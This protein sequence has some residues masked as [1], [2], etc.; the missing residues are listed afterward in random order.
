MR[1]TLNT[2]YKSIRSLPDTEIPDLVV[3]TGV[4]GAGKSHLLQAIESGAVHIEGIPLDTQKRNIRR[5]DYSNLVPADTGPYAGFNFKQEKAG[6]WTHLAGLITPMADQLLHVASQFPEL[7]ELS[8]KELVALTEAD[9]IALG[10]TPMAAASAIQTLGSIALSQEHNLTNQYIQQDPHN[11]PRL[12]SAI[13][14]KTSL[15]LVAFEAHDFFENFP[16]SWQPVDMF[17]QSFAKLF[18][19]YRENWRSNELRK[20]MNSRGGTY[21][22]LSD[23]EFVQ[24]YGAPPWDF[25]NSI[26]EA[27][28]LDFRINAPEEVEDHPYEAV[29]TDQVTGTKVRF[30]DLSSGERVLMSFALCLYY[31]NDNRQIVEYPQVLLFDEIDAPLHPSM[32]QSLLRTIQVVL[33]E[34]HKIKVIMTTHSPSTVALAPDESLFAMKK[35][36]TQRLSKTTKDAALS[37]LMTGVPTLS[38]SYENR[39]QV[40]VES[41]YDVMYYEMLYEKLKS[42]LIPEISLS[43]IA[44][45]N[46]KSGGCAHVKDVV[47]KLFGAGNKTVFGVVDWDTSNK[48]D[49]HLRVLGEGQRYSVE[50]YI[51]DPI[52]VAILL[53]LERIVTRQ[54]V[55]LTEG[56]THAAFGQADD[57]R[58]QYATD[59]VVNR[60]AAKVVPTARTDLVNCRYVGGGVVQQPLWLLN[61]QGHELEALLKQAFPQLNRFHGEPDLKKAVLS[62]VIDDLP[63][64]IPNCIQDVFCEIQ[65]L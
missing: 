26:L 53:F 56:E 49:N 60:L 7:A 34:Q 64:L 33:L 59:F 45:G 21:V 51:F 65:G 40:F 16:S 5:F 25:V 2:R 20:L 23:E 12:L 58:L 62:R 17:Q 24:R 38:I 14:A 31:A 47:S 1:L 50:N 22:V 3:L 18:T 29:L 63:C 42:K 43:F 11:R 61:M 6:L 32:T 35:G 57:S 15:N 27:A 39:R 28:S 19:E 4:N 54:E 55:G 52:L 37:L 8:V 48:A 41:H 36:E 44:A 10:M 46:S 13:R 9:A 30:N